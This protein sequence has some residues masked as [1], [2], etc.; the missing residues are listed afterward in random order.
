MSPAPD[1]GAHAPREWLTWMSRLPAE[2]G[3][4]G[5]DWAADVDRLTRELLRDWD[6]VPV[7][8]AM[9]GWTA[10]VHPV[11]RRSGDV[12]RP[13]VLKV[14]WP[15]VESAQEHLALRS[16]N[17]HGAVRLVAADPAR[18]ALLLERLDA[19]R[20]L[21]SVDIDEACAV[22][23]GLYRQLHVPAPPTIRPLEAHLDPYL[24]QL[25][26]R[27]DL[28]RRVVTR[29]TG[30]ARDLLADPAPRVLLHTDLHFQNALAA[31]RA[32]WLVIDPKPL[33]GPPAYELQPLLRN[34]FDE[35]GTG[36]AMRWSLRHRLEVTCEAAGIAAD[37]GR[38]WSIVRCGVEVFWAAFDGDAGELSRNLTLLKA[39][40][41]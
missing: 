18:G 4:T 10:V 1:L 16:W 41:D 21:E 27:T 20:D 29:V 5:A 7:G 38:L 14:G 11:Q 31:D 33:A 30:L 15:H 6:L 28:P 34:R 39:L 36:P 3:P 35:L 26:Q 23:G 37:I 25:R 12:T 22:I 8:P 2:G 17:G 32:P 9:T 40:E 13:L 19:T 24:T